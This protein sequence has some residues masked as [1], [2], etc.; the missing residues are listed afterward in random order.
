VSDGYANA[1]I[2]RFDHDWAFQESV[3]EPGSELGEFRLPHSVLCLSGGNVLVADR[4]NDRLQVFSESGDVRHEVDAVSRPAAVAEIS[5]DIYLVAE[6]EWAVGDLSYRSGIRHQGVPAALA[7]L[8]LSSGRVSRTT[9]VGDRLSAPHGLA[10]DAHGSLWITELARE[11]GISG[12]ATVK[13]APLDVV[14]SSMPSM[15]TT[16]LAGTAKPRQDKEK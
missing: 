8:D 4:E 13:R 7:L 1:R 9:F 11:S 6:L 16:E 5:P 15:P 14:L 12:M 3:G 10:V 2:H